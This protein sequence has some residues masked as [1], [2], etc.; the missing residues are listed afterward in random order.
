[1][2]VACTFPVPALG[3]IIP[4]REEIEGR[5]MGLLLHLRKTHCI[6]GKRRYGDTA[7]L[8]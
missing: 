2:T 5:Y 8:S 6:S 1:M 7:T 3:D 4:Q